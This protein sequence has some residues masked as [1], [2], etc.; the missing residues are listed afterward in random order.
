MKIDEPLYFHDF[1]ELSH[2]SAHRIIEN[3]AELYH[4]GLTLREI[5]K[6]LVASKTAVRKTLLLQGVEL[7]Q[8]NG[9]RQRK[10]REPSAPHI[11]VTPYGYTRLQGRL[12]PDANEMENVRLILELRHQGK[13]LGDIAKYLNVLGLKNRRGTPWEHSLVRNVIKRYP[14]SAMIDEAIA[15]LLRIGKS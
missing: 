2:S 7:R 1:I 13:S 3:A 6:R 4:S 12:I 9:G 11:G 8:P 5:A 14:D 10:N 15:S